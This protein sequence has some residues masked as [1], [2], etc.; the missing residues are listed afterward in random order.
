MANI[1]SK[2]LT[3]LES[4]NAKELRKLKITINNRLDSFKDNPQ[5]KDLSPSHPLHQVDEGQCRSIL[6]DIIRAE[7]K[8]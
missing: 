3:N 4:W 2:D 5:G 7:K 8:L 1:K 6:Q